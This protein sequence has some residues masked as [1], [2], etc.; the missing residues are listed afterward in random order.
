VITVTNE[1]LEPVL[2]DRDG[3][4]G[5][6]AKQRHRVR[7]PR[8]IV[9]EPVGLGDVIKRGTVALGVRPCGGCQERAARLNRWVGFEP[10]R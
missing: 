8:F 7:L 4:P 9:D 2:S 6:A 3:S 1:R 5:E 10:R